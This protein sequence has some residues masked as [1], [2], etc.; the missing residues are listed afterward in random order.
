MTVYFYDNSTD[1]LINTDT[2]VASG[3][4]ASVSWNGRTRGN[5]YEF[6]TKSNDGEDDSSNSAVASFT[7]NAL[8]TAT[9]IETGN[10]TNPLRTIDFSPY[11]DWTYADGDTDTQTNYQ[12]QV[13]TTE[14][15][16]DLWDSGSVS[17]SDNFVIYGG[18]ALSR[19]VRYYVRVRVHDG[20]EWSIWQ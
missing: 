4:S 6:Y 18:T 17:S 7:V 14:N 3:T 10:A 15:S 13:G 8:P 2:G 1:A 12:I 9:S 20:Y 19:G 11:F 5:T 16:S